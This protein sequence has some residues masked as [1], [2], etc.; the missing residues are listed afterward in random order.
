MK[1]ENILSMKVFF[2]WLAIVLFQA[3]VIMI[4]TMLAF[5][6]AMFMNIVAITFCVMFI[7]ECMIVA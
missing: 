7:L 5:D 3:S 6:N 2:V 4:A 1:H